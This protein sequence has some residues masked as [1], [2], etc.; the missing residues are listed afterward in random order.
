MSKRT[1]IWSRILGNIEE[2][3]HE[4]ASE[5][6][7]PETAPEEAHPEEEPK[8]EAPEAEGEEAPAEE[9]P[10][11]EAPEDEAPAEEATEEDGEEAPAEETEEAHEAPEEPKEEAAAPVMDP[12]AGSVEMFRTLAKRF[13]SEFADQAIQQNLS[14]RDALEMRLAALEAENTNLKA[15]IEKAGVLGET[16]TASF[17]E[18]GGKDRSKVDELKRK[19]L[20][21]GEASL[22]AMIRFGEN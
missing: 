22:G 6:N 4:A 15:T 12:E 9:A 16:E 21:E 18:E 7:A 8:D 10:E 3:A 19:G 11:D 2:E 5:E 13:G 14:L 17:A 20:S 1:S